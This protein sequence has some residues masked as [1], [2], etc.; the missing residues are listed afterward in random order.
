MTEPKSKIESYFDLAEHSLTQKIIFMSLLLIGIFTVFLGVLLPLM[1]F[2]FRVYLE[3]IVH[4]TTDEILGDIKNPEKQKQVDYI[5]LWAIDIYSNTPQEARYWFEPVTSLLIPS[6]VFGLGLS[7]LITTLL[8]SKIGFMRQKIEREIANF[9]SK[10]IYSCD[11]IK[12]ESP[13]EIEKQIIEANLRELY[14]LS[15]KW[16]IFIEDLKTLRLALIWKKS[17]IIYKIWHINYG[18]TMY[19]RYYFVVKYGNAMLGLVYMGAAVLI[20]IIGLRGLKFIPST[21]PSLVFFALGLEFSLLVTYAFTLMYGRQDDE[22]QSSRESSAD[23]D[24]LALFS[25]NKPVNSKE[26][27]NL[28]R[29]FIKSS[30]KGKDN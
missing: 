3:G 1:E 19:M 16:N 14:A 25:S 8:P 12:S 15:E 5:K 4:N 24:S 7:I 10:I 9:V 23:R 28:L 13:E 20:I 30:R 21:Q 17:S 2:I 26:V 11:E 18:L 29:V 27:E 6:I 22:T